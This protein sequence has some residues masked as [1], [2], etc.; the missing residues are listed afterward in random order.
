MIKLLLN[1]LFLTGP[2][3]I[4]N[5]LPTQTDTQHAYQEIHTDELQS[6]YAEDRE[7]ILLDARGD[8]FNGTLLPKGIWMPYN[9]SDETIENA[10]PS[11]DALLVV[12]CAN[13]TC[14]V[15]SMLSKHL[16]D[17]GYTNV[18]KYPEGIKEWV[19]LGLPTI[20]ANPS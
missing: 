5:T 18:Y 4:A 6:W 16:I 11:K 13:P 17:L 19:A 7:M 14:P 20:Q 9:A 3:Y 12:Y 1:A 2:F 10:L 15:S 8:S